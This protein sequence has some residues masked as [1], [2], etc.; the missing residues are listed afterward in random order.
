M[1][2][3]PLNYYQRFEIF[4]F[5]IAIGILYFIAGK[6][7][8]YLTDPGTIVS[9]IWPASG[10]AL[11]FTLLLGYWI[12]PG[13]F[14]GSLVLNIL[15]LQG[16][17]PESSYSKILFV[18]LCIGIGAALQAGVGAGLLHYFHHTHKRLRL[19]FTNEK[20]VW[21]FFC[22]IFVSTLI[23]STIGIFSQIL[24]GFLNWSSLPLIWVI[25]WF[26]DAAGI[27][28]MTPL[29][30][31]LTRHPLPHLTTSNFVQI[32]FMLIYTTIAF[33]LNVYL[34]TYSLLYLF[35]PV[36]I[37]A[38][39]R[40]NFYGATITNMIVASIT[41]LLTVNGWGPLVHDTLA[42]TLLQL[43]SFIFIV[44]GVTLLL[45]AELVRRSKSQKK[46]LIER[47]NQPEA[48]K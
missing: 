7:G 39:V 14:L 1:I 47:V 13:I 12:L 22:C 24:V 33:A 23:S 29:I 26:G 43:D 42:E 37:W 21:Q 45:A 40:F 10:V 38:S 20:S 16:I 32:I 41:V 35:A 2:R 25:W 28:I 31:V 6:L 8:F 4:I 48:Q 36:L 30:F 9:A 19:I 11:A 44:F 3:N 27:L 18:S 15:V 5:N 46:H 34:P 17:Y